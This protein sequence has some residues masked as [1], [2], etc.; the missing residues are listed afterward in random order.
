MITV[1]CSHKVVRAGVN[2]LINGQTGLSNFSSD[3]FLFHY[4][5]NSQK[6]WELNQNPLG[7]FK[8]NCGRG[9]LVLAVFKRSKEDSGEIFSISPLIWDS[10]LTRYIPGYFLYWLSHRLKRLSFA[11]LYPE[12]SQRHCSHQ[13]HSPISWRLPSFLLHC[14]RCVHL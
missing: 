3:S 14:L 8:K 6:L 5:C 11:D 10:W 12:L 2:F 13:A 1:S 9:L 7:S 4:S